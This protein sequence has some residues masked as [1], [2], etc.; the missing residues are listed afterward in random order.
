MLKP[1]RVNFLLL[2]WSDD[3][4]FLMEFGSSKIVE[5]THSWNYTCGL[6]ATT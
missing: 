4:V 6:R 2:E 3:V 1:L 5:V